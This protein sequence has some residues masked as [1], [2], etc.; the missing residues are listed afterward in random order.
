MYPSF[1][2]YMGFLLYLWKINQYRKDMERKFDYHM[3]PNMKE[4]Q[5]LRRN[6]ITN[7]WED[8]RKPI[9]GTEDIAKNY[10]DGLNADYIE[11][12]IILQSRFHV[13]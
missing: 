13:E 4:F 8:F 3:L 1:G 2:S 10:V 12:D 5:I 11:E 7:D 9:I 6:D